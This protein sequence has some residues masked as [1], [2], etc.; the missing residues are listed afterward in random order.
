MIP[1]WT[2]LFNSTE[3]SCWFIIKSWSSDL[4]VLLAIY[5][6][7]YLPNF[8]MP[9]AIN[10]QKLESNHLVHRVRLWHENHL[11][12]N[13]KLP[14]AS[15]AAATTAPTSSWW[16]PLPRPWPPA[17]GQ[18]QIIIM[19][20]RSLNSDLWSF[21]MPLM[22]SKSLIKFQ[23]INPCNVRSLIA[24]GIVDS[25]RSHKLVF[26]AESSRLENSIKSVQI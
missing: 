5:P 25:L 6:M 26:A 22:R 1:L 11:S 8:H 12:M 19:F 15:N 7:P 17:T 2:N 10:H 3:R 13:T 4:E 16:T 24:S 20:L 14:K 9:P 23:F 21:L 18:G